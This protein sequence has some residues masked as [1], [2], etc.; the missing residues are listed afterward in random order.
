MNNRVRGV[1]CAAA[2][3]S[4]NCASCGHNVSTERSLNSPQLVLKLLFLTSGLRGTNVAFGISGLPNGSPEP[5]PK[6]TRDIK[7]TTK[8]QKGSKRHQ[9]AKEREALK[10]REVT[11]SQ[12]ETRRLLRHYREIK[13][14]PQAAA[15]VISKVC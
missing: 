1:H 2:Q 12:R 8:A 9:T 10:I 6:I 14:Q 11:N 5:G 4:I 7:V 15:S 13:K 3:G